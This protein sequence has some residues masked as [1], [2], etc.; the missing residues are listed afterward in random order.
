MSSTVNHNGAL[1]QIKSG[2]NVIL[3]GLGQIM[4]QENSITGLLFLIGIFYGSPLMGLA[5][6]LAVICGTSTAYLLKYDKK[7]IHQGLYGFSAALVGVATLLF[8]K[9]H[10]WT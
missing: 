4:L 6:L 1:T 2:I 9:S 3:K 10:F 5:A 8:L 7:E